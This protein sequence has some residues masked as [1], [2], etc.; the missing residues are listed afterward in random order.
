MWRPHGRTH[1]RAGGN[2]GFLNFLDS[3]SPP[4]SAGVGRND[5][6]DQMFFDSELLSEEK[7]YA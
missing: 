6:R 3:D 7:L 5:V 2:P 1:S 4:A